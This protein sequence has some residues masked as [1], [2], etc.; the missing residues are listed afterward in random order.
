[1]AIKGFTHEIIQPTENLDVYIELFNDEGR[2]VS[3]HW[4]NS[5]EIIYL[6]SGTYN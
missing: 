2:Y 1:M 3:S 4:H 5:I 6:T